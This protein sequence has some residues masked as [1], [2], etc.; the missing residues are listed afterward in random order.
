MRSKTCGSKEPRGTFGGSAPATSAGPSPVR[1]RPFPYGWASKTLFSRTL[2]AFFVRRNKYYPSTLMRHFSMNESERES[3]HATCNSVSLIIIDSRRLRYFAAKMVSSAAKRLFRTEFAAKTAILAA[4]SAGRTASE[5]VAG[6]NHEA[7]PDGGKSG[8]A[9]AGGNDE[10][11]PDGGK[12]G[13]AGRRKRWEGTQYAKRTESSA[14]SVAPPRIFCR[15]C[16]HRGCFG[17]SSKTRKII[18]FLL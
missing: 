4:K 1:K 12:F 18:D 11:W 10:A 3:E 7:W 8:K 16:P 13:E 15:V 9:V 6:G 5:A 17:K 14:A 2:E